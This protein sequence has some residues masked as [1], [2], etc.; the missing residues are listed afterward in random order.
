MD[1]NKL[2]QLI[3]ELHKLINDI[4]KKYNNTSL[5]SFDDLIYYLIYALI[6][7]NTHLSST[8]SKAVL[9]GL[10]DVLSKLRRK[11]R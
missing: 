5:C 9:D 11:V 3:D 6:Q 1:K 2:H 8:I 10:N 4:D 7:E